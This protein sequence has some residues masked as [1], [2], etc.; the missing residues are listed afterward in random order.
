M[1]NLE[2]EAQRAQRELKEALNAAA[3][4]KEAGKG[5]AEKLDELR[6]VLENTQY[7]FRTNL[8]EAK[9]RLGLALKA[10]GEKIG[11]GQGDYADARWNAY[12]SAYGNA[13]ASLDTGRTDNLDALYAALL[14]AESELDTDA[15]VAQK[16]LAGVLSAA[17]SIK[18]AG[19]KNYTTESWN[20]FLAAYAA[21]EAGKNSNDP[22]QLLAL[23]QALVAAQNG[24]TEAVPEGLQLKEYTDAKTGMKYKVTSVSK[25][26]VKLVKAKDK[27]TVKIPAAVTF[28]GVSCKVTAIGSKAFS[29]CKKLKTV[30]IGNNVTTIEA[31]AFF[32]CKKLTKVN[33]G[34]KLSKVNKNAFKK[35]TAK[36]ITVKLP[37]NLKKN[38]K[39]KNQLTKAGIKKN[40][41]K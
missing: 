25:K 41:I 16:A 24:L 12:V 19:Q 28:E 39:L 31:N 2:T 38:K 22:A 23:Q 3:K 1:A 15:G 20:A 8:Q 6:I 35:C 11:L 14:K 27:A 36:K 26:T 37:K 34:K 4:I 18:N 33:V 30:T 29:G 13:F 9:Q 21:A 40:K 32:N 10:A 5:D 7:N 17:A